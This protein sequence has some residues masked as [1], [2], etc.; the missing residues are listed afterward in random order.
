MAMAANKVE[1]VRAAPAQSEDEVH[2]TRE[3]NDANVLTMG[4]RYL[5]EEQALKLVHVFLETAVRR[6]PPCAPRG[7]D[8]AARKI[9]A[10]G[11]NMNAPERMARASLRSTPK[12]TTPSSAKPRGR[13]GNWS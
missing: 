8:R 13:T 5:D 4:A 3:H 1:G 10:P 2:L 9:T 6:R 7:Q 11:G 12:F